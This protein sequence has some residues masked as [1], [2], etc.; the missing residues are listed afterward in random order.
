MT[1]PCPGQLSCQVRHQIS[2]TIL[3]YNNESKNESSQGQRRQSRPIGEAEQREG[4]PWM[5]ALSSLGERE[6]ETHYAVEAQK[7]GPACD[8]GVR[9]VSCPQLGLGCVQSDG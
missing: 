8:R 6:N 4:V 1:L 2:S 9:V 5:A 3:L 7:W